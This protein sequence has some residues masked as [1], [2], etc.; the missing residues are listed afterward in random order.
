[1]ELTLGDGSSEYSS[2]PLYIAST[3]SSASLLDRAPPDGPATPAVAV[4]IM[5]DTVLDVIEGR[6]HAVHAFGKRARPPCRGRLPMC[7]APGGRPRPC[8][9]GADEL[10]HGLPDVLPR[11]T[12]DVEQIKRDLERWGY[13]MVANALSRE[14]AGILRTAV[15]EQAAGER[16]AGVA[17]MDGVHAKSGDQPNQRVW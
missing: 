5:P 14:Q 8:A 10:G 2:P 17:H 16:V 1:M 13:A 15:E 6:L 4:T 3:P 9:A 12:E 11:P 7:F